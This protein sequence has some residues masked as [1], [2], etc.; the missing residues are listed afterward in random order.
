M[1]GAAPLLAPGLWRRMASWL[2]EGVLLFGVVVLA[3]AVFSLALQMRHALYARHGLQVFVFLVFALYFIWCW[4]KGQTLA[5]RTWRVQVVDRQGRR[6]TRGRALLRYVYSWIWVL[7]PLAAF[8][9]RHFDGPQLTAVFLGWV[10]LWALL[11]RLHPERQFWHDAWAGTRL[12]PGPGPEPR[13]K[14]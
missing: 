6:L 1:N 9:S 2:Y 14:K 3:G 10:V 4:S 13:R 8:Q 11:S 5:M 12:V 7:P